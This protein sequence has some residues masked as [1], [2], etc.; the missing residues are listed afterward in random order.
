MK[1]RKKKRKKNHMF[2]IFDTNFN[3]VKEGANIHMV[4]FHSLK[5]VFICTFLISDCEIKKKKYF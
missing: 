4:T 3:S 1:K 5:H 2:N